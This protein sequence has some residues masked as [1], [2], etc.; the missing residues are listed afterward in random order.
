[1]VLA[2]VA[3]E[4]EKLGS[5]QAL[6]VKDS[7]LLSPTQREVL[8]DKIIK[9]VKSY[10]ILVTQPADIDKAVF[11]NGLN[12]L[13]AIKFS[14]LI[15]ALKPDVAIVDCPSTNIGAYTEEL[16]LLLKQPT[17]LRCEHKAEKYPVVAAASILAKV[18]RDREI[19]KMKETYGDCGSGY[20][21]D[22]KTK[23]FLK[24]NWDKYPEI[25]RKSWSTYKAYSE[26]KKQKSLSE[27]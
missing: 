19:E 20:P 7:K 15:N 21:A 12:T 11:V 17:N 27:F 24:E 3:I 9:I 6:G 1:M 2:G 18:T 5:L 10:K 26:G 8:Y 14:Q 4:E 25:F 23:Q 16:K 13:E 22:P